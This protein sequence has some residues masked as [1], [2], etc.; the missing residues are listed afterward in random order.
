ML[1][2]KLDPTGASGCKLLPTS[3]HTEPCQTK[4]VNPALQVGGLGQLGLMSALE[5][6]C[7][8]PEGGGGHNPI[9]KLSV[10][11]LIHQ[12]LSCRVYRG[13]SFSARA[14]NIAIVPTTPTNEA[15]GTRLIK[16]TRRMRK[17]LS[18]HHHHYHH[19]HHDHHNHHQNRLVQSSGKLRA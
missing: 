1:L 15:T 12:N 11:S 5:K 14:S 6:Q 7:P 2:R 8:L 18:Y 4:T 17:L 3:L 19:H 10:Q 9:I 13:H 16:Q